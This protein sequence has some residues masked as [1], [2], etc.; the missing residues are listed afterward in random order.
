[1]TNMWLNSNKS[2][3]NYQ[4]W[5]KLTNKDQQQTKQRRGGPTPVINH[6]HPCSKIL[7][8]SFW[9]N[10]AAFFS[11]FFFFVPFLFFSFF[12]SAFFFSSSFLFY[13]SRCLFLTKCLA[14]ASLVLYVVNSA[15][16]P[17]V[18]LVSGLCE[19]YLAAVKIP[20]QY[21]SSTP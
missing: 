11:F 9:R 12:I 21:Y 16:W 18:H 13:F 3:G 17:K 4:I 20:Y 6:P 5:S 7:T 19:T 10:R 14:M 8:C 15:L 1:M 2:N